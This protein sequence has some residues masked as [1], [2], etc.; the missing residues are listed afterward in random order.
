MFEKGYRDL[1]EQMLPDSKGVYNV[2]KEKF[3]N[4]LKNTNLNIT[5]YKTYSLLCDNST[6]Q[7]KEIRFILD[8]N[9]ER[10]ALEKSQE[11]CPDIFIL[12]FT[13]EE[14]IPVYDKYD[15][16][17]LSIT[18]G[19]SACKVNG[20]KCYE[21]LNS[22][23]NNKFVLH[24]LWPSYKNGN[25]PQICNIDVDIPIK[26]DNGSEY[27]NN[28][29]EYWYT[30]YTTDEIFWTHEYNNHGY[31]YIKR[32]NESVNDYKIYFNK[33][34]DIYQNNFLDLFDYLYKD[35][36]EFP[37]EFIMN[38]T[39]LLSKLDE[40]Y[41]INS[42]YLYCKKF[43]N[44]YYLDEI[45]FKLDMEF[46]FTSEGNFTDNCPQEFM[47]EIME[48][49]REKYETNEEV[50]MTYDM[51]VFSMF[52]QTTTC[53]KKGFACY[54]AIENFPKK[55]WT[56]HGLWP[57]YKNGTISDWCNGDN[58]IDIKIKNQSLYDYMKIYWPGLFRTNE[59]F[60]GHEYNRH[61]YC[62]NQRFNINV[63]NYEQFFL[64]GIEIYEKYDL[65]NIFINMYDKNLPKGDNKISRTKLEGYLKTKGIERDEYLLIC[66][67]ITINN[68]NYSYIYEMRIRF[69]LDFNLYKNETEKLKNECPEEFMA[70]FL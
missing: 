43:E 62:Y 53:R 23:K 67:N 30:L 20:K 17:V 19:P 9:L 58:D 14:K 52:F 7:L 56:I 45:R 44:K 22:K 64:K 38:K 13:D 42:Y 48:R 41:S 70:E 34:L 46:N 4:L 49:P 59:G 55:M 2:S 57:N 36:S 24:G 63:N 26:Y 40:R 31:C 65:G 28:I 8:L 35:Y 60:W 69:D 47:V 25:I 12:N 29:K 18:Y 11:S 37:R 51:Y 10:V 61:G 5:D 16:Y 54:I 27:F 6:K 66:E 50:W 39:Y 3:R 33:A 15:F 68:K 32:I 1:M 21:I